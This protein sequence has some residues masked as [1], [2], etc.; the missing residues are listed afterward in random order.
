MSASAPCRASPA[1]D[2]DARHGIDA[3]RARPQRRRQDDPD[4][5][6]HHARPARRRPGV[7]RRVRRRRPDAEQVRQ[8][9]GVTGQ[10]AGL[11]EFLTGRENLELIGR[12]TGLGRRA[13]RRAGDL[14]ERLDLADLAERRVGELSGGSRRRIDLAAS[15]V[16]VTLG[17]VPRRT[18]D[19]PRPDRPRRA[20]GR[21]RRAHRRR[22]HRRAHHPIPRRGR[23]ARRRDRRASTTAGS[24]PAAH[25]PSSSASSAARS[26]PRRSRPS[27]LDRCRVDPTTARILAAASHRRP[28]VHATDA[29]AAADVVTQLVTA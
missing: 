13:R 17:A 25:P 22:H 20:V 16:G 9:I 4:P 28:L 10:Y 12:L 26:S 3:R 8:R 2:L 27:Q 29:G 5:S 7:H 1:I 19:R 6:A 15:L 24:P 11:D 14:I 21:R 23:P 18:D